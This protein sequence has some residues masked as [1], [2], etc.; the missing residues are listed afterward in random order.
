MQ[1][2][3]GLAPFATKWRKGA[4][5]YNVA[6]I[7]GIC[8]STTIPNYC[9]YWQYASVL[10]VSPF[11]HFVAKGAFCYNVAIIRGIIIQYKFPIIANIGNMQAFWGVAP[12]GFA[13][14]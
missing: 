14:R 4:F 1:A 2:F 11:C 12:F 8:F 3:W 5:C 10:G 9:Q 6:I 7:R 13:L